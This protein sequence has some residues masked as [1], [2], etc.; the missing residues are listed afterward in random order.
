MLVV[1]RKL[2]QTLIIND[3]IE[4]IILNT[5]GNKV[6]LGI[7]APNNIKIYRKELYEKIFGT[8]AEGETN[9]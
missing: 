2:N 5:T 1:T 4:I 6:R 3:D 9:E 7:N 8:D